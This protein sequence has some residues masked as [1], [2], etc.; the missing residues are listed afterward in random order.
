MRVNLIVRQMWDD[1]NNFSPSDT[2]GKTATIGTHQ[3]FIIS[4]LQKNYPFKEIYSKNKKAL[5]VK[6]FVFK[7]T[8]QTITEHLLVFCLCAQNVWIIYL[9]LFFFD[10]LFLNEQIQCNIGEKKFQTVPSFL[11]TSC[12]LF[13]EIYPLLPW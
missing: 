11:M 2:E 1:C 7:K 5:V 12:S 9:I 3:L 8:K 4:Y 6:Y 10:A 13:S